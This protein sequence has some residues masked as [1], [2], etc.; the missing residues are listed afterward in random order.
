MGKNTKKYILNNTWS[1]DGLGGGTSIDLADEEEDDLDLEHLAFLDFLLLDT[2]LDLRLLAGCTDTGKVGT[3]P[4][5]PPRGEAPDRDP[6]EIGGP[7][8]AGAGAK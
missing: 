3:E 6:K 2:F 8:G 1:T 7:N 4:K 5:V